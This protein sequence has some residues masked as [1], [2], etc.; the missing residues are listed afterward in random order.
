MGARTVYILHEYNYVKKLHRK[1][2]E[3]APFCFSKFSVL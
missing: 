2:S 1:K 3:L